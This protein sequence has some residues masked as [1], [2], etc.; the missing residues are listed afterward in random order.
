MKFFVVFNWILFGLSNGFLLLLFSASILEKEKRAVM[1]SVAVIAVNAPFWPLLNHLHSLN[2]SW[3]TPVNIAIFSFIGFSGLISLIKFFPSRPP[4][5]LGS[6]DKYDERDYM[7]SRNNLQNHPEHANVYY[8]AHPD[9]LE[10]DRKIHEKPEIGEPGGIYFDEYYS[11]AFDASFSYLSATHSASTGSPSGSKKNIDPQ[12]LVATIKNI[13]RFYGAVDVGIASLDPYHLYS[14]AG[15]HHFHW[16]EEIHNNHKSAIVIVVS[17]DVEMIKKAP[18]LPV[19]LESSRQYVESAKIAHIISHYLRLLGYDSRAH[20]DGNY[21]VMCVPLAVDAGIGVLGRLGLFLHP[22]YGPCIRL[23]VVTTELDL[24]SSVVKENLASIEFFCDICK[25]CAD[26]CPTQSISKDREPVSRGF[27]HW[28]INQETCFSY[29]K[30]IGT[31]C[32]FCIGVCPYTKP[33]TFLHKLVRFYISRNPI[34]Q[35]IALF[36][37]DLFYGRKKSISPKNP[38]KIF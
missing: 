19:I 3:I 31:D 9:K 33:D 32:G 4:R 34:N 7:F 1:I 18:A 14:H 12:K 22:I 23:S 16:G 38:A 15:R 13:A 27:R 25:K 35:R 2:L 8:S 20:T 17:M 37:D 21:E 5:N 10:I 11:P 6:I 24:P 26:N 28:S 30:N 29:W 36:M